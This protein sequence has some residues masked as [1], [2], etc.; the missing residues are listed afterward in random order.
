[1]AVRTSARGSDAWVAAVWI[2]VGPLVAAAGAWLALVAGA[3]PSA[4][5]ALGRLD[6][7]ARPSEALFGQVVTAAVLAIAL[8]AFVAFGQLVLGM[9][10]WVWAPMSGVLAVV[11][12]SALRSQAVGE[13]VLWSMPAPIGLTIGFAIALMVVL[14][15]DR[16]L[17]ARSRR[18]G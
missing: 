7:S 14:L 6:A 18:E 16:A 17:D 9:P 4:V 10:R 8:V 3:V 13:H 15:I 1:M 2:V 12:F 11:W 5:A